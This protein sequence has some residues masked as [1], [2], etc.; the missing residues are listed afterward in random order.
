MP[1]DEFDL[2]FKFVDPNNF[3]DG[4]APVDE[5]R[6]QQLKNDALNVAMN[7]WL[8]DKQIENV[9]KQVDEIV[10]PDAPVTADEDGEEASDAEDPEVTEKRAKKEALE[11]T[12][13]QSRQQRDTWEKSF[14]RKKARLKDAGV[15]IPPSDIKN[16][17]RAFLVG[18]TDQN[19]QPS[20][21]YLRQNE[22]EFLQ[23]RNNRKRAMKA[24]ALTG[25]LALNDQEKAELEEQIRTAEQNMKVIKNT[26]EIMRKELKDLGGNTPSKLGDDAPVGLVDNRESRRAN[27]RT[28]K[29]KA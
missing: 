8:M 26:I 18:Q 15:T 1:V 19:G 27:G 25:A 17:K 10:V 29:K 3:D 6:K 9:Q 14:E 13:E 5:A 21:G 4:E 7:V 20:G 11:S 22:T 24:I 12:I 28:T 2:D 23:H 16:A